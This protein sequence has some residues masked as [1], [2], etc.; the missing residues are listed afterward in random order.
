[1]PVAGAGA[2]RNL[3][4]RTGGARHRASRS[5][6]ADF[7]WPVMVAQHMPANFTGPFARRLD[8]HCAL[9]VVE[10]DRPM[11]LQAGTIYIGRGDADLIVA[12]RAAGMIAMPVPAQRD[13]PW[14]PSVE[15][16]VT[17][18]ARTL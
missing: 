8:R 1:M 3:D 16:M 13:Y 17:Q 9:H 15:R 10:V 12:P 18:R 5:C 7:P 14:H 4:R 6:R 2:D 11:P